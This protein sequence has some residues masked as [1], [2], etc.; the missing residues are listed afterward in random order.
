MTSCRAVLLLVLLVPVASPAAEVGYGDVEPIL[1][2]RCVMCH[3]GPAA[4]LG[5]R[6]DSLEG[7]LA[8]SRDGPIAVAGDPEASELIRRLEG[9]SLPRMPMT[10]PPFLS[11]EEIALF[12]QWIAGGMPPGTGAAAPA[13]PGAAP[14]E[15]PPPAP[16]P[17]AEQG[18]SPAGPVTWNDVAVVFAT[19]CAKC[20]TENGLLGPAPEGYRLTSYDAA[21]SAGERARIVP[22]NPAASEVM[23]RV[24]GQSKPRMPFDGPPYLSDSEIGLIEQWIA[25][26]ARDSRGAP[27]PLPVGQ[28]VRL[29]GT[30]QAGGR[31]NGLSLTMTRE[32]RIDKQPRPGDYVQVRGRIAPDG[33][34]V[35]ER[36]RRR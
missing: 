3:Q 14:A 22:G 34:V 33:S 16:E 29:H 1:A 18:E 10:G 24:L 23:R 31:L 11:D 5:L 36:L 6:L 7:V 20:H 25:G 28:K 15:P 9:T 27:A 32:T 8:G 12:E 30:L 26:G 17:A 2:T 19:R 4:P 13:D 35:V 21:V